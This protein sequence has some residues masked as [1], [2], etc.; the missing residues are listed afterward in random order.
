MKKGDWFATVAW[1]VVA[2]AGLAWGVLAA[3]F[4]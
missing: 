1:L 4:G 2:F 3:L